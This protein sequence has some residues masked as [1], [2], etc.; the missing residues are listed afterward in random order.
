MSIISFKGIKKIAE[1]ENRKIGRKAAE[2]ISKQLA[3]EAALLLK[4]AS[5]NAG[6]SGRVT[7]REE[8]IPD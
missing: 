1:S 5:A 2:K 4:K 3:R 7:I 8:D 6:L